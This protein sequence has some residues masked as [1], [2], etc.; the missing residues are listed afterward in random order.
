MPGASDRTRPDAVS[1]DPSTMAEAEATASDAAPSSR[2]A[3]DREPR[4][5]QAIVV[6]RVW[7]A[8]FV[9]FSL[10]TE[11]H[12]QYAAYFNDQRRLVVAMRSLDEPR[13][14][15]FVL[16]SRSDEPPTRRTSSTVQGW[17]SHNDVT[18][19]IDGDGHV[20]LAGNMHASPLTY[21]RTQK[22]GDV[23]TME[24]ID[25][26]VGAEED[27]CTYPAFLKSPQ[28]DLLF[29]YRHGSS[30]NG[31]EIYNIYDARGRRWRRF[32]DTPLICGEGRCN[33]YQRGPLLGPDGRRHLLW[34]WRDT[35][36][37]ATNHDLSYARSRDLRHWETAAGQALTLPITPA[38]RGTIVD[39]VPVEGGLHNS[40]HHLG[41]DHRGRVVATY[42][43]HDAAGHTQACAARFEDGRWHVRI[44]SHWE[45]RHLFR[46][47]GTEPS[48][49]GTSLKL[50]T[51]EP[52]GP[53]RLVLPFR[54]WRAGEGLLLLDDETLER[55]DVL[56]ASARPPRAPASLSQPRSR[57]AG[58]T[59][60]WTDDDGSS[61][62]PSCRYVLRW[63]SLGP[64]RD[65]P[66]QG[67][68]PENSDL[69]LYQF[70]RR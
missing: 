46:G 56:P 59:V 10:L 70:R 50:G 2:D 26:M 18:L 60:R 8:A 45:G 37:V 19:A 21:F 16:P 67:P 47:Y 27:Q 1:G 49:F 11:G 13:F 35:P 25:A 42:F 53:G 31:V 65:R 63:E 48:T 66:R 51:I 61:P 43:K 14:T 30:G 38:S 5:E 55:I 9:G 20:H 32:L 6:D 58:M 68:L 17:D 23:T 24:Q 12:R 33:A 54:H 15:R 44:I 62:D 57:F 69:V 52:F 40:E 28:G 39:P 22:P 34:M 64:N 4:I 41:F 3:A 7:S 29:H 36:D